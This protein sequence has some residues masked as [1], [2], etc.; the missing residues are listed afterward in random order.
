MWYQPH[1]G[2][3]ARCSRGAKGVIG[4]GFRGVLFDSGD[5]L[6]RPVGGRWNP[7]PD[8]EEIVL[9]H[10][11]GIAAGSFPEAFAAGQEVLDAGQTTPSLAEYHLAI[12]ASS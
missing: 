5:T 12:R 8:F 11:P 9:R 2:K 7:Q 6:I 4:V 1:S 10:L 3:G